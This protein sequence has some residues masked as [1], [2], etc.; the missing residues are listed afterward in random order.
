MLSHEETRVFRKGDALNCTLRNAGEVQPPQ[1]KYTWFS[2]DH[3]NDCDENRMKFKVES[4]SFELKSQTQ[5]VKKY[6][7]IATNAAGSDSK[8]VT[9]INQGIVNIRNTYTFFLR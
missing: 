8:I 9:V 7:C 3:I 2:C 6:R 4:Y 1:V 5:A